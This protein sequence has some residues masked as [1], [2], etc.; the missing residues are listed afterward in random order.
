MGTHPWQDG[1]LGGLRAGRVRGPAGPARAQP[2]PRPDQLGHEEISMTTDVYY[3][4][5]TRNTGAAEV[6]QALGD[7][8]V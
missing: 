2:R 3:G 6:L 8:P 1:A 5:R 7:G 4:R